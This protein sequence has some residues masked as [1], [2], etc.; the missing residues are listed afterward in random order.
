MSIVK[1]N[2]RGF[3][4]INDEF[5]S[6]LNPKDF[7]TDD[8]SLNQGTI[9]PM[10]V[11]ETKSNFEVEFAVPGFT[12][13]EIKIVLEGDYLKVSAHTSLEKEKT[14]DDY[15]R[16]EFSYSEF[17][18]KFKLPS[19]VETTKKVNAHYINGILTLTLVK[20]EEIKENA[21]KVIEIT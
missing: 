7:F 13:D 19:N 10:N 18:R 2:R 4:W 17:E 14:D 11:K 21:K 5:T 3:P 12:K 6:L 9:P 1:S 8:F 15:S 20:K 16:K